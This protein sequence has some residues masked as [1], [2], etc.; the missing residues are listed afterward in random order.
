MTEPKSHSYPDPESWVDQFG[1]YLYSYAMLRV[2][3][4]RLAEDIVQDT[5]LAALG[6]R[7]SY[8]GKASFK[9]WLVGIL[10]NKLMDH[11][12]KAYRD[13][14]KEPTAYPANTPDPDFSATGAAPGYWQA[15]RSPAKWSVDKLDPVEQKEFWAYLEKCLENLPPRA[16]IIYV[17]REMEELK[18]SEICNVLD[19]N[20]TNLR[21]TIHRA[22]K[23]LRRCLEIN[24]IGSKQ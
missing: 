14:L 1:D 20:A 16:A 17:L 23:D 19:L 7:E 5:F 6:A 10:K 21:V 12:R 4:S 8:S 11:F 3:D 15:D 18:P 9:T 2:N 22:R 24:W 13:E